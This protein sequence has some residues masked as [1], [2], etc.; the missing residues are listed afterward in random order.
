M[1]LYYTFLFLFIFFTFLFNKT[2]HF[3]IIGGSHAIEPECEILCT[4]C[5][6]SPHGNILQNCSYNNATRILTQNRSISTR[7]PCVALLWPQSS[8]HRWLLKMEISEAL[9]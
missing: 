3:E 6:I 7:I 5:P 4:H 1:D 8:L 2:F 9:G